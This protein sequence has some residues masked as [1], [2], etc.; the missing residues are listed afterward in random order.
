MIYI[1]KH[2]K[3][4]NEVPKDYKELGVGDLFID[5]GK[6]NIN[7]LNKYLSELTGLYDMWKNTND[8]I[9]GLCHYRRMFWYN[10]DYL[11]IKDAKKILKDYDIIVTN[12]VKFDN[13]SLYW[14]LRYEVEDS[15]ILDKYLNE[16]YK[17]VPEFKEYLNRNSFS[18]REM[19]VC[20]R[21]LME[22]YCEWV[23][24]IA[25]PITEK[26]IKEDANNLKVN[27][28]LVSHIVERLFDYWVRSN[29][30]KVY[31]MDYKNI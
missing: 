30:L 12:E 29:K 15:D 2:R 6:D 13:W 16:Y 23:F 11:T 5:N 8:D 31:N 22:K 18:N 10:D 17:K 14:Q 20:K 7:D 21:E 19:F 3:Y 4:Y 9:V 26:F 1:I 27:T 28:R 24:P 25:I